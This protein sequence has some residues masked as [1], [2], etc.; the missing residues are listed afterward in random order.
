[1]YNNLV[2]KGN[3]LTF[4]EAK[5]KFNWP[6]RNEPI[7]SQEILLG[8]KCNLKCLFC[9]TYNRKESDWISIKSVKQI[10]D[11]AIKNKAWVISFSGGEPTLYPHIIE[12]VEYSRKKGIKFIQIITNGIKTRDYKFSKKLIKAGLNE[13]KFSL[14]SINKKIHDKI[15]GYD[16]AFDSIL[17]SVEN[18]N[19]LGIK[20]AF[21]FAINKLNYKELPVFTELMHRYSITG[22]CFMFSFY[23]GNM[24]NNPSIS[25]SYSDVLP[26]LKTTLKYIKQ[27]KILIETKML[28]NFPPCVIP[29]YI[30]LISDWKLDNNIYSKIYDN[31]KNKNNPSSSRK[32]KIK[33]CR[34]CLYNK[35]CNGIDNGYLDKY[36]GSEFIPVRKNKK[37]KF[38]IY[39]E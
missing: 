39:Y 18:F 22:F 21:N 6:D 29:E 17:K 10:I 31:R 15:V 33:A 12:A 25:V 4:E 2:L 37:I 20:I 3:I 14:H 27:K 5:R 9:S 13:V 1:M 28:N 8:F 35:L 19:K 32:T 26:Y 38:N 30:D 36:G 11:K 24:L 23:E 16:G 7:V 34:K